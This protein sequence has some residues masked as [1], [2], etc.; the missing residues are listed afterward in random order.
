[1]TEII[2]GDS[3]FME[4]LDL[5]LRYSDPAF[6]D[7]CIRFPMNDAKTELDIVV[8][9]RT[10][11]P[12]ASLSTLQLLGVGT[13]YGQKER[14][15][16]RL[17][18]IDTHYV[19]DG[20]LE[21]ME[22]RLRFLDAEGFDRQ[23]IFPTLGLV[24]EGLVEDPALAAAHCRAYN[25]WA[26]EVTAG[27]RDRLLPF[28]H[29]SLRDPVAAVAELETLDAAGV[30]GVFVAALPPGGRSLGDRDFDPVWDCAAQLELGIGLH[31]VVHPHY[32]GN[33]WIRDRDPGFMFLSMN[34]IQDPR[35]AL[36]TMVY[37]G[38]FARFPRL[39]VATVEAASGWVV[40]W[41]D[42]LDYR[43]S[44]MGHTS[45]MGRPA[46]EIFETNLWIS[47]DPQ[48]RTLPFTVELLGDHKFFTGSDFPHLE[49]FTD[50]VRRTRETLASLPAASLDRILGANAAAFL[51]LD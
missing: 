45:Q 51:G 17:G 2:D 25:R 39:R 29:V 12:S 37:D 15:G 31:L 46:S 33:D 49:G 43:F 26:L 4:P 44:Y 36:T 21:N 30:R 3:H 42:R 32:V 48:E 7:R 8:E 24:W 28:G 16:R 1:M 5:W 35:M 38:V 41:I 40:E 50:P 11:P 19:L 18:E 34:C 22:H 9:G 47:A 23:Y 13:G 6:R 20:G 27:C 10:V 14:E